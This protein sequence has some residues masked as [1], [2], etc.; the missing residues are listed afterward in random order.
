MSAIITP[1]FIS[2]FA[3]NHQI[4]YGRG[5]TYD[6]AIDFMKKNRKLIKNIAK[7]V[8]NMLLNLLLNLV[9]LYITIKLKEKL[10]D[11]Q[12]EKAKNYVSMLLSYTGVPQSVI[13]Q[14]RKINTQSIPNFS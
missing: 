5:S 12:I 7:I 14:I 13:A 4:I 8:L 10:A 9:L 2:L 6:G 1:E 11:D 3:I